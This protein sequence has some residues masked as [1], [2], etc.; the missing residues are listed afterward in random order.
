MGKAVG[1]D[2]VGHDAGAGDG[3]QK[4]AE[5][6]LQIGRNAGVLQSRHIDRRQ[7]PGSVE[8]QRIGGKLQNL[9]PALLEF[10][11]DGPKVLGAHPFKADLP[12]RG[13]GG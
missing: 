3:C 7:W 2:A 1:I 9:H 11:G 13:G 10:G 4:R 6:R 12:A 5:R 8:Q